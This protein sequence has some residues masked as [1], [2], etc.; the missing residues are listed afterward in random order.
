[1][2]SLFKRAPK[3]SYQELLKFNNTGAGADSSLRT[4]QDGTGTNT[5]LQLSTSAI[6]LNGSVWPSTIGISGQVLTAGSNGSMTWTDPEVPD[7]TPNWSY[8]AATAT[9]SGYMLSTTNMVFYNISQA[10]N[11][12]VLL[13]ALSSL[14]QGWTSTIYYRPGSSNTTMT[15]GANNSPQDYIIIG[16]SASATSNISINVGY[17]Y[18]ITA[19][20]AMNR[21]LVFQSI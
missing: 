14:Y 4:I 8:V 7:N 10:A 19:I 21:W 13:P 20:P 6:S 9:S 16:A 15:L 18:T 3:D 5:P 12:L 2:T 11:G 1:M 17:G